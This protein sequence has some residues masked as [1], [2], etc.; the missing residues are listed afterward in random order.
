MPQKT[1]KQEK[2]TGN[3]WKHIAPLN[4]WDAEVPDTCQLSSGKPCSACM[5][6]AMFDAQ[7]K[8]LDQDAG[9]IDARHQLLRN[10][11]DRHDPFSHYL[12]FELASEIFTIY[13]NDTGYRDCVKSRDISTHS[14]TSSLPLASV[15]VAWR[16]IIFNIPSL[17]SS[18]QIAYHPSLFT[19]SNIIAQWLGRARTRPLFIR[20]VFP[21]NY[22]HHKHAQRSVAPFFDII[23]RY[24][25]QWKF[26]NL[27]MPSKLCKIFLAKSLLETPLLETLQLDITNV[28]FVDNSLIVNLITPRL[29][30]LTTNQLWF[31]M[32]EVD[33]FNIL[34]VEHTF[35][36]L[37][38]IFELLMH[39]PC[40]RECS[41]KDICDDSSVHPIPAHFVHPSIHTL[42]L[43]PTDHMEN[44]DL[45]TF[46]QRLTFPSLNKVHYN[47]HGSM[48][49]P[50][51]IHI[52]A[53]FLGRSERGI[54]FF[55]LT[56]IKFHCL[57]PESVVAILRHLPSLFELH[58][59]CSEYEDTEFKLPLTFFG[60]L[61]GCTRIFPAP[62]LPNLQVLV[63]RASSPTHHM[64][65]HFDDALLYLA[66][67]LEYST[68][69]NYPSRP[70]RK[71]QFTLNY[72]NFHGTHQDVDLTSSRAFDILS[73][74]KKTGFNIKVTEEILRRDGSQDELDLIQHFVST[75]FSV[76]DNFPVHWFDKI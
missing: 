7:D 68:I 71:V 69:Y 21:E 72:N 20:M 30:S 45:S 44:D 66:R 35:V 24:S 18:L 9:L 59:G 11:N 47:F 64:W 53:D 38:Q 32:I 28:K 36:S 12:P 3:I 15:S 6:L 29:T 22:E 5:E 25:D 34:S 26:L 57:P 8:T 65:K 4:L 61:D 46:F 70:L 74:V 55:C 76:F 43:Y 62:F 51:D 31:Q 75:R 10:V 23:R 54:T 2:G 33:Y 14:K 41:F 67:T 27:S 58:L 56:N 13:Y 17:W 63:Y 40:L 19:Q 50:L 52:F 39:S 42:T 48:P 16:E 37:D 49:L 73:K 60:H 1:I